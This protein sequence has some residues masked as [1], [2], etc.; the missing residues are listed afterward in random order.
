MLLYF[1]GYMWIEKSESLF[2]FCVRNVKLTALLSSTEVTV[3]RITASREF[4]YL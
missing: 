1:A 3:Y 4:F 2:K